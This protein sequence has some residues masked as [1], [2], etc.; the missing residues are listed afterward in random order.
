MAVRLFRDA[1]ASRESLD[2]SDTHTRARALL[3]DV[4]PYINRAPLDQKKRVWINYAEFHQ[5]NGKRTFETG[6]D[7][8]FDGVK[9]EEQ[10]PKSTGDNLF[11]S[12][13]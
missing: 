7:F 2:Y 3:F 13:G 1:D 12:R 8:R 5:Q 10:T 11:V 4:V 6:R 9:N